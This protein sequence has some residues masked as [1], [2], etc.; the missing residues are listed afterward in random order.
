MPKGFTEQE[1]I[2]ITE[3]LITECKVSWQK[4]GYKKTSIDDLCKNAGISK[5]AFYLFFQTKELLFMETIKRVQKQLYCIVENILLENQNRDGM[6]KAL[7]EIYKE[8]SKSPF[9]YETTSVDFLSFFNKLSDEQ[10]REINN[11]SYL[12][13]KIMLNKSYLKLKVSEELALSVL[14]SILFTI[15]QKDKMIC[16]PQDAFNFIIDNLVEAIFE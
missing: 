5:G 1:K 12:G 10:Q 3:K 13:A 11:D 16:E 6:A 14:T 2:N 7:K 15:S 4:Y 9:M 8:Y